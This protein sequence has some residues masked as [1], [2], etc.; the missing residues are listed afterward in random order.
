MNHWGQIRDKINQ[1]THQPSEQ[2]WLKIESR[3]EEDDYFFRK[4][5]RIRAG[6]VA[7][8]IAV[9]VS[10]T[11]I[12]SHINDSGYTI[13][14]LNPSSQTNIDQKELEGWYRSDHQI[15][16]HKVGRLVPNYYQIWETPLVINKKT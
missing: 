12:F 16:Y 14:N 4:N 2:V 13:E 10:M 5:F 3:M 6:L 11:A 9:L 8:A 15:R 1:V 7:A